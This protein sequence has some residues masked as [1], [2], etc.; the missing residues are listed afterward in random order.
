ME[1]RDLRCELPLQLFGVSVIEQTLMRAAGKEEEMV[2]HERAYRSRHP[3]MLVVLE[4]YMLAA[5]CV[6]H[7]IPWCCIGRATKSLTT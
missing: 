3:T 4:P 6:I 7:A 5:T 2:A 1:D